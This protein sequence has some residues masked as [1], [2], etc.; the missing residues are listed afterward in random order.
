MQIRC[1]LERQKAM[2]EKEHLENLKLIMEQNDYEVHIWHNLALYGCYY[3][4]WHKDYIDNHH[5][6]REAETLVNS[7]PNK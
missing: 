4:L 1:L 3:G 2:N 6:Q 7:M 5:L